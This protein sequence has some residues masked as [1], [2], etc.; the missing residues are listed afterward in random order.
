MNQSKFEH[1]FTMFIGHA[2]RNGATRDE[3][4]ILVKTMDLIKKYGAPLNSKGR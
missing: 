2:H 4:N 3:I 1:W